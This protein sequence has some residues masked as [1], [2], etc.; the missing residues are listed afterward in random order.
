MSFIWHEI[1]YR[2]LFNALI[3]LYNIIPG[4][5]IG[6]AIIL[7][8]LAIRFILLP[9]SLKAL[10]AQKALSRLQ[11]ELEKIKAQHKDNKEAQTKAL[12]EFYQKN[13]VNP[14]GSCLPLLI[15]LPVLIA[16][17]IVFSKGLASADLNILYS[18]IHNPGKLDPT[19]LNII[20]LSLPTGGASI[21]ALGPIY[22]ILPVLSGVLQF[23]QSWQMIPKNQGGKQADLA[24]A[25]NK[26]M[27]FIFPFMTIA[28]GAKLPAGLPLYWAVTTL[29]A[30]IQQWYINK[31][32]ERI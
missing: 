15:Q 4:H 20:D 19:F 14:L 5:D 25:L 32:A 11:P 22:F 1:I 9:S 17:Y 30:I 3:F 27:M 31:T 23:F 28:I 21:F 6:V 8:T 10:K 12:M 13:K 18:F 2:P 24:V 29:F 7:L 26:Q 16:L